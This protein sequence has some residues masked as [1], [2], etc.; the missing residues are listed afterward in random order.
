M[1]YW[2]RQMEILP[3]T[4]MRVILQLRTIKGNLRRMRLYRGPEQK[5]DGI[6]MK[7]KDYL[8]T[9]N[10]THTTMS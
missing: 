2:V 7:K 8:P 10:T 4:I 1:N 5:R 6:T 3:V 9:T